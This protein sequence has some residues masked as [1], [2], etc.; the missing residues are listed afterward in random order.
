MKRLRILILLAL[1][2]MSCDLAFSQQ[3]SVCINIRGETGIENMV[4]DV[5][6]R[7]FE[8][9]DNI[10][11]TEDKSECHLYLDLA[12]VEQKPIRF[13]GLGV[14]IAYRLSDVFYSRPTADVAQF[15]EERMKE[16]CRYLAGEIDKAFL[17]PLRHPSE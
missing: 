8:T 9:F 17:E 14:C 7:E 2:N 11:V 6:S 5:I 1:L 15:G 3:I 4:K 12:L 16:V 10:T 13:Y